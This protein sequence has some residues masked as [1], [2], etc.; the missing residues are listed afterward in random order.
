MRPNELD[1]LTLNKATP[2]IAQLVVYELFQP[3]VSWAEEVSESARGEKGFGS[4]DEIDYDP[5]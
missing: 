2:K 1:W 3:T 4:S 5:V